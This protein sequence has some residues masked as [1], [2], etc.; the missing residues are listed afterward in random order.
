MNIFK[1]KRYL[2]ITYLIIA[3][4]AGISNFMEP[5]NIFVAISIM[6][7]LIVVFWGNEMALVYL[8]L[9]L[10]PFYSSLK[11]NGIYAGSIISLLI[12]VRLFMRPTTKFA[13]VLG[14]SSVI[15]LFIWFLHD[16]QFVSFAN[17]LFRLFIP[18]C[19]FM[20]IC[21]QRFEAYDGFFAIW[22]VIATTLIAMICVF[23][24]QGG[25]IDSFIYAS[26][27]G[28]MRLGEANVAEGQKN[29]LGGAMGFPIYTIIIISLSLQTLITHTFKL[30]QKILIIG[31]NM[32]LFFITF[33]TISRVYILGIITLAFLL[34]LHM[35]KSRSIKIIFSLLTGCLVLYCI[36]SIYLPE[37]MDN[38]FNS[39]LTRQAN[40]SDHGGTGIRGAIYEDCIRYLAEDIECLLIGKGSSAYPLFGAKV[41]RLFSWSAHNIILDALMS[42]G[43]LGSLLLVCLYLHLYKQEKRRLNIRCSVLRAMPLICYLMMNMTAT[44]FLLDKTYPMLFFL[45]MNI[46]HCTDNSTKN[47]EYTLYNSDVNMR[48]KI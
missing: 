25:D 21:R 39:Y 30:W 27:A 32:T 26:Y 11:I 9:A 44:P 12:F 2:F 40:N 6:L 4:L 33:L 17:A 13:S 10:C 8:L 1:D 5:A 42:F 34:L 7:S 28:E 48:R 41:H 43:V 31:L 35:I 18:A 20:V 23:L 37:Y 29:Q 38:V 24:V 3:A 19:V 36:A 15:F 47:L 45:I 22:T 46:T 14:M 16:I